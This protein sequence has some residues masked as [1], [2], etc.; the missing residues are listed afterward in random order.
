[1]PRSRRTNGSGNR[2]SGTKY[3]RGGP[4]VH[5]RTGSG[6]DRH[7]ARDVEGDAPWCAVLRSWVPVWTGLEGGLESVVCLDGLKGG[8]GRGDNGSF[9]VSCG[10]FLFLELDPVFF[11]AF[12]F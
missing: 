6:A 3:T 10:G 4:H 11:K 2:E 9:S 8:L 12:L 5:R 1:M 7:S